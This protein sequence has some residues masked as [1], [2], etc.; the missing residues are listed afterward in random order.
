MTRESRPHHPPF[1]LARSPPPP[2]SLSPGWIIQQ[3]Q[4]Q[5]EEEGVERYIGKVS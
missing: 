3:Q 5:E 1:A 2:L 4:Q